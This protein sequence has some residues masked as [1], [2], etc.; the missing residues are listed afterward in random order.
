MVSGPE[1]PGPGVRGEARWRG[2]GAHR[3]WVGEEAAGE[4]G[5]VKQTAMPRGTEGHG[6]VP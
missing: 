1:T 5:I 3:M 4:L 2:S 6:G